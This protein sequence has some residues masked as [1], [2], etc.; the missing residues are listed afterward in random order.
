MTERENDEK[1]MRRCLDL[2]RCGRYGAPPNPMVGAVIVYGG[3]ILGEGYHARCGEAHAE[4]AAVRAV[5]EADKAL[6][7][8]STLYV[9]LEPCAHYGRTPPCAELIAR[10]GIGRVVVGCVDPFARVRGR[11]IAMLREAGC[12]VTVGVLEA[13]CRELNRRFITCQTH[14]RPYVMLKWA[15]SAD[16][17]LDRRRTGGQPVALSTPRTLMAVHRLR[18][19]SGAIL[20]GHATLRLDR[21]RLDVRHWAGPAPLRLVLGR[22]EPDELPEGFEAFADRDAMLSELYRRGVQTLLVEGGARTLQ[23]FIA[24]GLWDEARVELASQLLGDGVAAPAMPAG[25]LRRV[26]THFGRPVVWYRRAESLL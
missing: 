15:Q 9:S 4:V 8:A 10:L 11:G 14:R 16:G 25:T 20:V 2:A 13:E 1:W 3:R 26:E 23:S 18:A 19:Q 22:V 24:D 5:R 12:D 17:F 6:L 7:P 21:P